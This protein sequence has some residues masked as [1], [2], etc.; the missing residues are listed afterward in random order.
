MPVRLIRH[1]WGA[2][3]DGGPWSDLASLIHDAA[4]EGYAGVEFPL[5]VLDADTNAA[6]AALQAIASTGLDY[7]PMVLTFPS[8]PHDPDAHLRALRDQLERAA[9][10]GATRVNAHAG[11]DAFDDATTAAFLTDS[12]EIARAVGIELLHE[13]HRSRPLYNPWRT[14]RMVEEV[15]G[16]RLTADYSH[17]VCVSERLPLDAAEVFERCAPAVGH[18]HAR[19]G[20]AQGPQV[21]DPSDPAWSMELRTHEAWW[22]QIVDAAATRGDDMTITP[23]FGPPPYLAT[24][25]H[26]GEPVA[27]LAT[28]VAYMRDRLRARYQ[29]D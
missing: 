1:A 20:H 4:A 6:D 8:S 18:I 12:L 9:E 16:L 7:L 10:L 26:T 23:E 22:D 2:V 11:S 19:V 15:D 29:G 25:P 14:A 13:T 21:P 24:V 3:G 28:V 27:D 5:F 17:W